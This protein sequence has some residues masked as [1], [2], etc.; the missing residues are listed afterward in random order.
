MGYR[1]FSSEMQSVDYQEI[2][3]AKE[4]IISNFQLTCITCRGLIS[5]LTLT[6][7]PNTPASKACGLHT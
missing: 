1:N 7:L 4:V 2:L 6:K 5:P 3:F